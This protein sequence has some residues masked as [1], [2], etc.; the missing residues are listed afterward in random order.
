V[1]GTAAYLAPE[2]ARGE[3]AGPASDLYALGVVAYQ[4]LA[5]RLPYDAGSLTDLARLQE[6]GPPP[7]LDEIEPDVPPA[8]A[9]AVAVAL[10]RDPEERY[11]DAAAME[12]ALRDGLRGRAPVTEATWAAEDTAAT[13]MLSPTGATSAMP[14]TSSQNAPHRRLE[15][16]AD[17]APP[18]ARRAPARRAAPAPAKKKD[19]TGTRLFVALVVVIALAIAGVVGYNA[20]SSS[21]GGSV[22]L[23]Q[24]VKGQVNDA[25]E[26][27]RGVIEDNTQ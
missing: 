2:Q 18:P 10:H 15:P 6:T 19:N 7:R 27:L 20:L 14:Q 22:Q 25:I 11:P 1:L 12:Q 5:G 4:L 16:I 26:Q 24:D 23:R 21:S 17:S 9:T 13:R 3:A 8:L